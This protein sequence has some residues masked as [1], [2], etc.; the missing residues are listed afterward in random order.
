MFR[1]DVAEIIKAIPRVMYVFDNPL[2]SIYSFVNGYDNYRYMGCAAVHNICTKGGRIKWLKENDK[3]K[4]LPPA[5]WIVTRRGTG[6]AGSN[7]EY[8]ICDSKDITPLARK[9]HERNKK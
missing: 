6:K 4:R 7:N 8:L 1:Q 5:E 9:L 3:A 2:W